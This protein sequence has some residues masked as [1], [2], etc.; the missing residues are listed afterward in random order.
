MGG[1]MMMMKGERAHDFK[2]TLIKLFNYLGK[3]RIA[4]IA[5]LVI[6]AFSTVF[7]IVGP[8]IMGK[9]TTA[10]FDGVIAMNA[11]TA[12]ST[13]LYR[14]HPGTTEGLCLFGKLLCLLDY[15]HLDGHH[16]PVIRKSE[17]IAA[18]LFEILLGTHGEILSRDQ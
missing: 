5:A 1:P 16:I 12:R 11:G 13:C 6:A 10:L 2:G 18:C 3:Y 14:Q 9:A 15:D 7:G 4:M 17:K 8:K